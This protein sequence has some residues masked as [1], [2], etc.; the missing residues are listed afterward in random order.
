MED[1]TQSKFEKLEQNNIATTYGPSKGLDIEIT[2]PCDNVNSPT[3]N[4]KKPKIVIVKKRSTT[5]N[6]RVAD[7]ANK[8]QT[9]A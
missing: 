4:F 3:K 1:V 5:K 6:M 7:V 8:R 2:M 9:Q